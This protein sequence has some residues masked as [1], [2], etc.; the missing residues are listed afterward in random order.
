MLKIIF[1]SKNSG[2]VSISNN[3][4]NLAIHKILSDI[5]FLENKYQNCKFLIFSFIIEIIEFQFF[6]ILIV[7]IRCSFY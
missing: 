5:T 7:H 6:F 1:H 4:P 2:Y 3:K